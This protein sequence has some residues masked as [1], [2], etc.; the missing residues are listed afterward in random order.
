MQEKRAAPL[1]YSIAAAFFIA[2]V[3]LTQAFQDLRAGWLAL[4]VAVNFAMFLFAWR[5]LFWRRISIIDPG[6]IFLTVVTVYTVIPLV[7][8]ESMGFNLGV[9]QD[10]RLYRI[11]LDDSIISSIV[12]NA[13]AILIGFGTVY[14]L[15][16]RSVPIFLNEAGDELLPSL[17]II[18]FLAVIVQITL[19]LSGQRGASYGDEYLLIQA[20]PVFIIQMINISVNTLYVALFSIFAI[21]FKRGRWKAA[22]ILLSAII[23]LFLL[24]TRA[25]TPLVLVFFAFLL[26][27]D[28][29]HQRIR[30]A[31]ML[32]IFGFAIG[33][34]LFLGNLRGSNNSIA[35]AFAQSEFM[36]VFVTALDVRQVYL[37]GTS[38]GVSFLLFL[39][40]LLRLVPQQLLAFEKFDPA[41]W[42]VTE[43]YP[44]YAASGGG[45]AFGM[46]AEAA[47]SGGFFAALLRGASLGLLLGITL[48]QLAK[49]QSLWNYVIYVWLSVS[50]YQCFRD[51]TF[52]LLGRFAFQLLPALLLCIGVS[53][54]L[55]P[56]KG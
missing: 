36:A 14:L 24:V 22:V 20:L 53:A 15:A 41:S 11:S 19:A 33:L 21:Y 10:S 17:W 28:H 49:R 42:Y 45:F 27:W 55:R 46:L 35:S 34:F 8:I 54:L 51:T 31:L 16:R 50:I 43:F 32:L 6:I 2:S 1:R 7:T 12:E 37:A 38:V 47:L 52:T 56:K 9:L 29:I 30:A 26:C 39:S 44:Q 18:L 13:N 23:I 25:R 40:D 3:L 5:M 4:I 48:N